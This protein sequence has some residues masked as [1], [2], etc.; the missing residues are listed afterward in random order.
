[1]QE[2]NTHKPS[3]SQTSQPTPEKKPGRPPK[4]KQAQPKIVY[5]NERELI[6]HLFRAEPAKMLKNKSYQKG[7]VRLERVEHTHFFH[8]IDSSGRTKT[9][10][11]EVGGHFHEVTW[12]VD[13]QTGELVATC[14]PAVHKVMRGR[15]PNRKT[16]IEPVKYVEGE[17]PYETIHADE[18]THTMTYRWSEKIKIKPKT[19]ALADNLA[20]RAAKLGGTAGFE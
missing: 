6:H 3:T 14:G 15:F 20:Q 7:V 5:K 9:R 13:E 2:P 8:T 10:T 12:H 1:M 19:A 16:H 18:H 17:S 11:N 4:A